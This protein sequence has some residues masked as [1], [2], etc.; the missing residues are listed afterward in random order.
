MPRRPDAEATADTVATQDLHVPAR[1]RREPAEPRD[2][3]ALRVL[4]ADERRELGAAG[5]GDVRHLFCGPTASELFDSLGVDVEIPRRGSRSFESKSTPR[6]RGRQYAVPDDQLK[7]DDVVR[8]RPY[9]MVTGGFPS[10][11]HNYADQRRATEAL[12]SCSRRTATRGR[13]CG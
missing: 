8:D 4:P 5:A 3:A 7:A 6:R 13:R 9:L 2:G 12:R 10:G 1:P 11:L